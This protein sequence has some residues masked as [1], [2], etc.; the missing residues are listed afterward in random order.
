MKRFLPVTL[1]L[2][3]SIALA[4]CGGQP[5]PAG[6]PLRP[7]AGRLVACHYAETFLAKAAASGWKT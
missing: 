6:P 7:V 3:L 2:S 5:R 4:A 1:A